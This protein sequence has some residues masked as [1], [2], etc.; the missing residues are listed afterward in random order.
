MS[1]LQTLT[2]NSIK[3]IIYSDMLT[4][5]SRHVTTGELNKKTNEEAV[6]QSVRN[7]LMTNHYERLFHPEIGSGLT[8]M[9]FENFTPVT[10]KR[11]ENYIKEVFDKFEPRADLVRLQISPNIDGNAIAITVHFKIKNLGTQTSLQLL[12]ERTR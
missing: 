9:L 6:K 2:P 12:L 5:F 4:D 10:H 1:K 7:L 8:G 11:C 3:N